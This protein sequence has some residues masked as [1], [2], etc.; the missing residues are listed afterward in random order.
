[1]NDNSEYIGE[2]VKL[3]QFSFQIPKPLQ[4]DYVRKRPARLLDSI[5]NTNTP[6]AKEGVL[7]IK[8]HKYNCGYLLYQGFRL[9]MSFFQSRVYLTYTRTEHWCL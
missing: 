1:L 3:S 8:A 9:L 6:V 2:G 4:D 7:L 5:D